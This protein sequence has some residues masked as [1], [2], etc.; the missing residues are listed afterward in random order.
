MWKRALEHRGRKKR[1]SGQNLEGWCLRACVKEQEQ[2]RYQGDVLGKHQ[3]RHQRGCALE[4]K[5]SKDVM[6]RD[7]KSQYAWQA[8]LQRSLIH[9][10]SKMCR[11]RIAYLDTVLLMVLE[12]F[13][14]R[15]PLP[16]HLPQACVKLPSSAEG[17]G[18]HVKAVTF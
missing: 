5:T 1:R 6:G 3:H 7:N 11:H 13:K 14:C 18:S 4:K 17:T 9:Q 12:V 8:S 15:M 16:R 10:T 2:E